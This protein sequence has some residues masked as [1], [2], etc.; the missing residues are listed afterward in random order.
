MAAASS[1]FGVFV[2]EAPA[3]AAPSYTLEERATAIASPALIYVELQFSGILRRRD[4][5]EALHAN[6]IVINN[7]CS[8]FI[9]SGQGHAVTDPF[10]LKR[11]RESAVLSAGPTLANEMIR[12]GRL[13]ADQKDAFVKG[14]V[15]TT[16]FTGS[17]PGSTPSVRVFGQLF[18]GKQGLATEPAVPGEIVSGD[19]EGDQ[20]ALIK[21]VQAGLPMAEIGEGVLNVNDPV[22]QAGFASQGTSGPVTYVTRSRAAK[23]T[24]RFGSD[25]PVIYQMDGDAGPY[26]LGG[27]AIDANGKVAGMIKFDPNTGERITRLVISAEEVKKVMSAAGA[28]NGLTDT[29]IVYRQGLDAYF[30]GRYTE[31]MEKLSKVLTLMPDHVTA[32]TYRQNAASRF[33]IEGEPGGRS[34]AAIPGWILA[35]AVLLGIGLVGS[36][37]AI[38]ILMSRNRAQ[39]L[40][41]RQR[42]YALE[43]YAPISAIPVS[44]QPVSVYPAQ[45]EDDPYL[46]SP[47]AQP[48]SLPQTYGG[49]DTDYGQEPRR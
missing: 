19:R 11:G 7:R 41:I 31:A 40:Q 15:P 9:V 16:D 39:A 25:T 44:V 17:S 35:L 38:A 6:P 28:S 5:G 8:G 34:S 42:Q 36:L 37:V 21:F 4:T 43:S 29:D 26:T 1:L 3:A 48:P 20:I 47:W 22:V 30:A 46:D 2:A 49:H 33:A 24:G 10:C 14:L 32:A 13:A 23:V 12:D 45:T 27:M 18:Q